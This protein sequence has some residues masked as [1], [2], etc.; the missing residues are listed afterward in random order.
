MLSQSLGQLAFQSDMHPR[1]CRRGWLNFKVQEILP[2][3]KV[4]QTHFGQLIIDEEQGFFL[5]GVDIE[6][7][8]N[9][10]MKNV[11]IMA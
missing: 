4:S 9:V 3:R 10:G 2:F 5:G 8:A 11:A 6:N 1:R 7:W